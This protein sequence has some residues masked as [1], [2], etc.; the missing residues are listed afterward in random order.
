MDILN[1]LN[2]SKQIGHTK[3]LYDVSLNI[4]RGDF[5]GIIGPNG[6]GKT[7]L[8]KCITGQ[9]AVPKNCVRIFN[10]DITSDSLS[11]KKCFGYA[12]DPFILPVQLTGMQFLELI[13]SG[14]HID[15]DSSNVSFFIQM[16]MLKSK[17]NDQIG[18]YSQ[19]MKQKLSIICAL[20]GNPSLIILDESL[21]GLD[22]ISLFHLKNYLR[23][24]T[25]KKESTVILSSHL[26]DSIE[27]YCS[28]IVML[29]EGTVCKI[30]S[31]EQLASEKER[32][33]KDL[34]QLF[35]DLALSSSSK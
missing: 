21:N 28:M 15:I 34:E 3:I 10:H 27:K 13:A 18:T 1:I 29:Y 4:Q 17:I 8:L 19:G 22:P 7:T 33:K 5:V 12:F 26:I 30:W 9:L 31:R 16:L 20:F 32:T 6:A 14:R 35:I 2:L 11:A 24:I 25:Q 23:E